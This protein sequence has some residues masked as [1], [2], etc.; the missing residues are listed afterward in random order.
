V[1]VFSL[2]VP[3]YNERQS[4]P[5]LAA[6]IDRAMRQLGEP[7]EAIWV[8]DGSTDDTID[9]LRSLAPPHRYLRLAENSGQSA[10]LLAGFKAARGSWIGTLDADG[11]NDPADLP[12][13]F[14]R[15]REAGVDMVNGVRRQRRDSWLRRWSSR[16][17][18]AYRRALLHDG[19]SDVGC[20]TRVVRHELVADLPC[21]DGMHRFLPSLV[22]ARGAKVIELEVAHRPRATGVS[23]YGVRNRLWVGLED[24]QGVRWLRARE[25]HITISEEGPGPS[26]PS[27]GL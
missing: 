22:A 5:A 26:P 20:S 17:A 23:K 1:V 6:E 3:A 25:R 10:A 21:F 16:L 12:R 8:D 27:A 11:Q 9:V 4:I 24:V 15:A 18:N 2:V 7:W 14:H 19:A 13:L